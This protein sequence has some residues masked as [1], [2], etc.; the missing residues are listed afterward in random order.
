MATMTE[1][2]EYT[3]LPGEFGGTSVTN[4]SAVGTDDDDGVG[5]DIDL[6]P[7][8][9]EMERE[10]LVARAEQLQEDIEK[11]RAELRSKEVEF[12]NVKRALGITPYVEFKQSISHGWEVLGNKWKG[13]Q[14]SEGYRKVDEKL[15]GWKSRVE[16]SAA[17]QKTVTTLS[18]GSKKATGALS[19]AGTK[20][21]ENEKVKAIGEKTSNALKRTGTAIKEKG[22]KA[23]ST[24]RERMKPSVD[25]GGDGETTVP[26]VPKEEALN[27]PQTEDAVPDRE[28]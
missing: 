10:R 18:D 3:P 2:S 5:E 9:D 26:D 11:L 24:L 23:A 6:D 27:N 15:T 7:T 12:A 20:I 21:K 17:Y 1:H 13:L 4:P 22:S 19:S 25:H 14:E 16:E 28:N 8:Q